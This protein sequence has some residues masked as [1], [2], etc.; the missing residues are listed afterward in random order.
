MKLSDF[1]ADENKV[2]DGIVKQ[3]DT[4]GKCYI[5]VARHNNSKFQAALR[6]KLEPFKTFRRGKLADDVI[7]KATHEAM[8]KCVLLEMVGFEDDFGDI[9][10]TK[11]ST[12]PDTYEN[13]L[14]VL[15]SKNYEE[16]LDLVSSISMDFEMFKVNEEADDLGN[17]KTGSAGNGPG[18]EKKASSGK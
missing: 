12:I 8:A 7:N 3:F 11:G 18:A 6:Q 13:R 4:E 1:R 2:K 5:R 14:K 15:S 9:T 10:G 16:F 17:S